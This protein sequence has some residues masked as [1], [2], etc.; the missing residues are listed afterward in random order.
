MINYFVCT[1][2]TVCPQA[3]ER[4][5]YFLVTIL[6][7]KLEMLFVMQ[8]LIIYFQSTLW[9]IWNN[10]SVVFNGLSYVQLGFSSVKE[11]NTCTM[12]LWGFCCGCYRWTCSLFFSIFYKF[13]AKPEIIRFC[14]AQDFPVCTRLLFCGF[15]IFWY[16]KTR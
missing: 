12:S 1:G 14:S 3:W 5:F 2:V 9:V 6:G 8:R 10:S 7:S 13:L 15:L 11:V 16:K 4:V